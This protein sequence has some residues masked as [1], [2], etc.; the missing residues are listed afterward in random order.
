MK[1][2]SSSVLLIGF[3]GGSVARELRKLKFDFDV[4]ELDERIM[5][6]AKKILLF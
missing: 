5:E 3:G 4:V 1:D 6:I 2:T